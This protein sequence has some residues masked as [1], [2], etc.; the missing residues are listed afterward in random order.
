MAA[1]YPGNARAGLEGLTHYREF[2]LNRATPALFRLG[3]NLN[4]FYIG[5][6]LKIG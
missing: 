1:G 4:G 3:Q 2:L 6:R 5:A